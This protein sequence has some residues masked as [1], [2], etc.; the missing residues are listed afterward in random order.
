MKDIYSN[1]IP[2][3]SSLKWIFL[4]FFKI[5]QFLRFRHWVAGLFIDDFGVKWKFL[6]I[7]RKEKAMLLDAKT[8]KNGK[9]KKAMKKLHFIELI[10]VYSPISIWNFNWK[11]FFW[12]SAGHFKYLLPEAFWYV[13]NPLTYMELLF[14]DPLL[15]L[16]G[17]SNRWH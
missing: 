11:G 6:W 10:N 5:Y 9:C 1:K 14:C 3:N 12:C 4:K 15:W 2:V 8:F 7:F 17:W 13:M 16:I